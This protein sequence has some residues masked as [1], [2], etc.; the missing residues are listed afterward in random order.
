MPDDSIETFVDKDGNRVPVP[1][2]IVDLVERGANVNHPDDEGRTPLH[3][4]V[5]ENRLSFVKYLLNQNANIYVRI[6]NSV[7]IFL[8]HD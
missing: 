8:S 3:L 6:E 2:I 4:A 7:H 1:R 5:M